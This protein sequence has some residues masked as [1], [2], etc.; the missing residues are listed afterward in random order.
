M[1]SFLL[2]LSILASL[3][4]LPTYS[5]KVVNKGDVP[6][7]LSLERITFPEG[8]NNYSN[9]DLFYPENT[10]PNIVLPNSHKTWTITG[11]AE[12]QSLYLRHASTE[13]IYFLKAELTDSPNISIDC[14]G[15][16]IHYSTEGLEPTIIVKGFTNTDGN[17]HVVCIVQ[18][19]YTTTT[20]E[21]NSPFI[22]QY[23]AAPNSPI[24]DTKK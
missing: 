14:A 12:T 15:D 13:L 17:K 23:F 1:R 6:V 7:T 4:I 21:D 18:H 22:Y 11:K 2:I 19:G 16:P 8:M 9:S 5:L 3:H 24:N 10:D 20:A